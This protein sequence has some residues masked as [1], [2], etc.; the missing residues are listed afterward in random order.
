MG[1]SAGTVT[2]T[3]VVRRRW[4]RTTLSMNLGTIGGSPAARWSNSLEAVSSAPY[5]TPRS[6]S[7]TLIALSTAQPD[8]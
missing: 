4:G 6:S 1:D 5:A 7:S 8:S 3:A 2:A